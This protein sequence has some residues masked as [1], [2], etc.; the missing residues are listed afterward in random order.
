MMRDPAISTRQ[1]TIFRM[2]YTRF[3]MN[4]TIFRMN[5]TIFRI[6]R[7]LP[8]CIPGDRKP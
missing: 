1:Y 5:C 7:D 8:S 2:N 6:D 4:Y 3:R